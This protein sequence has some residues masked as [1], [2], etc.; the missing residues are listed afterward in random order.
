VFVA[1][2]PLVGVLLGGLAP[3]P[4][5]GVSYALAL[6]SG[7]FLYLG[8]SHLLIREHSAR[9]AYAPFAAAAGFLLVYLLRQ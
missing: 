3:L 6:F 1:L 8:G 9:R 5:V 4:P 7:A 2:C